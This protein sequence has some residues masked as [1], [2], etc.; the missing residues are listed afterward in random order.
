MYFAMNFPHRV[1]VDAKWEGAFRRDRYSSNDAN[2]CSTVGA[3]VSETTDTSKKICKEN[4]LCG[5]KSDLVLMVLLGYFCSSIHSLM[6]VL[7]SETHLLENL[8]FLLL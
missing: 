4:N 5:G 2:L 8:Y 3:A 6:Q 1:S 7:L